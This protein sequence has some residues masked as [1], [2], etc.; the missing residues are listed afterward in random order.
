MSEII[1]ISIHDDRDADFTPIFCRRRRRRR[2]ADPVLAA[3]AASCKTSAAAAAQTSTKNRQ[4]VGVVY[5]FPAKLENTIKTHISVKST[6][7]DTKC[8][9]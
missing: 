6:D 3:A 1:C 2:R 8:E 9:P 4:K 5:D 7:I